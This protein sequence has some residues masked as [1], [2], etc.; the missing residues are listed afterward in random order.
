MAALQPL[1]PHKHSW[2]PL[3]PHCG[4]LLGAQPRCQAQQTFQKTCIFVG[5]TSTI[6]SAKPCTKAADACSDGSIQ[7]ADSP[8]ACTLE[9]CMPHAAGAHPAFIL[10]QLCRRESRRQPL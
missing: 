3:A 4:L 10:L 9:S 8:Q 2:E 6:A 5:C 1:C 7:L